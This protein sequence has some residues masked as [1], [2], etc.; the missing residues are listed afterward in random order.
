MKREKE[1]MTYRVYQLKI[2]KE[3]YDYG[4]EVGHVAAAVKYPEYKVS[5]DIRFQGSAKW[6]PSMFAYFSPVC[7]MDASDLEE[8]FNIGNI[9]PEEKITRLDRMHSVSVGDIIQ[10]PTG[11]FYMVDDFGFEKIQVN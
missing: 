5:R 3:V 8:V 10:N 2:A 4:N 7:E 1:N 6:E 11:E 9:G